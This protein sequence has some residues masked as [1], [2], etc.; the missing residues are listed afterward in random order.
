M[1]AVAISDFNTEPTV[2]EVPSVQP[3]EGQ[4]LVDVSSSSVNGMDSLTW[5]GAI[6]GMMPYEMPIT[7]G[8]D[9]AGTVAALGPGVAGYSVGD[10]VFGVLLS[11]PLHGGT[12]AEQTIVPAM[13]VAKL[14]AGLDPAVAG[15]LGLAGTAAK[16]AV[17]ALAPAAGDT[18]LIAG[19]TGGVGAIAIQLAKAR[20]AT[21]VATATPDEETAF[22]RGLGADETVDYRDDLVGAVRQLYPDGVSAVLHA[23]G[24]GIALADLVVP[25]GRYASTL[26]IGPGALAGRDVQATAVMAIPLTNILDELA[27]AVTSGQVRVPISRTY[28]LVQV[29]QA[30]KDFITGSQGKIAIAVR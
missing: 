21:V 14:P 22:V 23:A 18:V 9:F 30:M 13:T 11:M 12:F 26:G 4:L 25:G 2:V 20:G 8:R 10:A 19:A 29:G 1:K 6:K 3:G 17:D 28:P 5:T 27:A 24:D 15:A 16:V 7:L